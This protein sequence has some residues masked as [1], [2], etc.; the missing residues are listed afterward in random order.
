MLASGS[1][2]DEPGRTGATVGGNLRAEPRPGAWRSTNWARMP[3]RPFGVQ[4]SAANP[5]LRALTSQPLAP[6][7]REPRSSSPMAD[8]STAAPVA[9]A[10][11]GERRRERGPRRARGDA[12]PAAAG[13]TAGPAAAG[14][15]RRRAPAASRPKGEL[16]GLCVAFRLPGLRCVANA[17]RVPCCSLAWLRFPRCCGRCSGRNGAKPKASWMYAAVSPRIGLRLPCQSQS[18]RVPVQLASHSATATPSL[19][20]GDHSFRIAGGGSPPMP[21]LHDAPCWLLGRAYRAGR[22]LHEL[23]LDC[24]TAEIAGIPNRSRFGHD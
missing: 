6:N 16:N 10:K 22:R 5:Q 4:G 24:G 18:E 2:R 1:P 17:G 19:T 3:K 21:R 7:S 13:A 23:R 14:R 8:A 12:A 9:G 11:T 20:S 15:G